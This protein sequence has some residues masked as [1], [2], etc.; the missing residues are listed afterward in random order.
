MVFA[1]HRLHTRY[2]VRR[3]LE[4][5][6]HVD[7]R[8]KQLQS[9][10]E[11]AEEAQAAL[12]EQATRDSL[13]K[14]WNRHSIFEI[15]D[16]EVDRSCREQNPICVIMADLD[17]FKQINDNLGHQAG[18]SVLKTVSRTLSEHM[19]PYDSIGRYGG[20]EFLIVLPGCSIENA[21]TRAEEFRAAVQE[22]S[23]C[24]G[25]RTFAVTCSFGVAGD[26]T[27]QDSEA[28]VAVADAA[29]YAAKSAGRNRVEIG[30]GDLTDGSSSVCAG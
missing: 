19:R 8:T 24:S 14:L 27:L 3:N 21:L 7:Q 5:E 9:A 1:F 12:K 4:L 13:T 2:L 18:D 11:V 17:H 25:S 26:A 15:L 20:E 22:L 23:V 10:I 28:F 6:R 29:L 16:R 30:A